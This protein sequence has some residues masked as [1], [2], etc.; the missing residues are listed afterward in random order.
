M[1]N[2]LGIHHCEILVTDIDKA[3][4]FYT[5]I[6]SMEEVHNPSTFR[7]SKWLKLGNQE[8]HLT[9]DA[10]PDANEQRHFAIQVKSLQ[11]LRKNF[12]AQ[13]LEIIEARPIPGVQRF[14]IFDPFG[15]RIE[16]V[17][18]EIS[19]T[20]DPNVV[21]IL[22][23]TLK[24]GQTFEDFYEAWKP[25]VECVSSEGHRHRYHYFSWPSRVINMQD[26]ANPNE[27]LSL[28]LLYCESE[29]HFHAEM[30]RLAT[31]EQ[32]RHDKI[33]KVADKTGKNRQYF[34]LSDDILG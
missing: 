31:T 19:I 10:T 29:E 33:A 21:V 24:P 11:Q 14:F 30:K 15:N 25:P 8:I 3:M 12:Q 1:S 17:E 4:H 13:G 20:Q 9:L 22:N 6:L 18:R 16:F 27:I 34:V 7:A 23:R 26:A 2:Y 28:G 32:I 5:Q